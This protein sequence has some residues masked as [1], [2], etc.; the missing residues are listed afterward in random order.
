MSSPAPRR[1]RTRARTSRS[2][3]SR[4]TWHVDH[5]LEG[6]VRKSGNKVR[7]T[8]Q[9]IRASDSSHLWSETYDRNLERHLRGAGRDLAAGR[10]CAEIEIAVG[11]TRPRPTSG[12]RT[13]AQAYEAYLLG[14]HLMSQGGQAE[15]PLRAALQSFRRCDPARPGLCAGL[16]RASRTVQFR[17]ASNAYDPS[18]SGSTRRAS[19]SPACARSRARPR[20]GP[21]GAGPGAVDR[22][23]RRRRGR[24][25]RASGRCN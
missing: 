15:A 19:G 11:R 24:R 17:L 16:C 3:T 8:T 10:R 23:R 4:T 9:L 22:R 13:I 7:I 21:R 14:R 12:A 18:T 1:S 20:R 2:P 5:V 25:F 6:S